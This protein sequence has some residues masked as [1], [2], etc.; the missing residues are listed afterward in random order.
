MHAIHAGY[1]P[2]IASASWIQFR[3]QVHG[4]VSIDA[5]HCLFTTN[6]V[7]VNPAINVKKIRAETYFRNIQHL[8]VLAVS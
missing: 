1:E 5:L 8:H 2:V 3:D 6:V 4:T 7:I